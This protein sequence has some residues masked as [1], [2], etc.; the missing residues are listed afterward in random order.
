MN[1]DIGNSAILP[2]RIFISCPGDLKVERQAIARTLEEM[3]HSPRFAERVKLIPYLYEYW[4]PT[5]VGIP[6]QEIVNEYMLRPE[7]ADIVICMVWH[8]MGTPT[9]GLNNP[10]TQQ[11]YQSGTEYEFL[12]ALQSFRQRQRPILMLLHCE[13][14]ID[15]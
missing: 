5:Q 14:K 8:K 10:A 13:R 9:H 2:V 6:A 11:P 7:D 3:N 1:T 15:G 4:A 12:Q